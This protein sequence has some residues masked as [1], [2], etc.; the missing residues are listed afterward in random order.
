MKILY[1][2]NGVGNGHI[3]RARLIVPKLRAAGADVTCIL[4][5]RAAEDCPDLS[6]LGDVT[7]RKG[8]TISFENGNMD[9]FKNS[10]GLV[11]QF[12]NL[13]REVATLDVSEYDLVVSDF[14]PVCAWAAKVQGTPCVAT[15]NHHSLEFDV[16]RTSPY[17][18]FMLFMRG[19]L[20]ADT[21]IPTHYHH[22]DQPILP[23]FKANMEAGETDPKKILV[24]LNFENLES[25]AT[26]LKDFKDH[27]F[28]I[29]NAEVDT[30]SDEG[31]LHFRPLSKEGFKADFQT[32][33][34]VITN[35]GFMTTAE[36]LQMGKKILVKPAIGQKEQESN[37][38]ALEE[39][40]YAS[41]MRDLD[42]GIVREWLDQQTAV[43]MTCP[44]TAQGIVDWIMEGNWTDSSDLVKGLW[45]QV[46]YETVHIASNENDRAAPLA[47][48]G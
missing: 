40:G 33:A 29:Y 13:I 35:A 43:K 36:A 32:S 10:V 11:R 9:F 39:L 46:E 47:E 42:S 17:S 25:T 28:Y 21:K 14:E 3:S 45:D 12:P 30:P 4:S 5:G 2:L 6:E 26:L 22:F 44:D 18:P 7:F 31:N 23:P 24:Y 41:S 16:P 15:A 38:I 34:G 48:V 8:L 19:I 27:E 37:V 1:G 20:P